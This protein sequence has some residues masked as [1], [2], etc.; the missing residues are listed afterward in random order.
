MLW[1]D[2]WTDN[3]LKDKFLELFSFARKPKCSIKFFLEK[4]VSNIFFLP[5]SS[6]ASIQLDHLNA[7][8]QISNLNPSV[9]DSW[10]YIWDSANFTSSKAYKFITGTHQASPLFKWLWS[11]GNLRKHKFFFWLLLIDRLN[12][13]NML[14]RKN[15]HLDDYNCVFCN[16]TEET[17]FHL[18]SSCRFSLACWN[19]IGIN[20]DFTLDPLDM[21][22]QARI[23]FNSTIF[24]ETVITACWIIWTTRK[25]CDFLC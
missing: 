13:R 23:D 4:E 21:F 9:D 10:T 16:T 14:K 15:R 22:C 7:I 1:N 3:L 18:F 11:A 25:W 19:L 5:L 20:W 6:Q 12:T 2:R 17:C 8:M 24:R